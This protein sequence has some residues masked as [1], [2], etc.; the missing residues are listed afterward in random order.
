MES[1]IISK[2]IIVPETKSIRAEF[3]EKG[4]CRSIV[5]EGNY[6]FT[7]D[8]KPVDIINASLKYYGFDL[9]GAISGSKSVIGSCQAPPIRI[10]GR[11]N[12]YW[13]P[14]TLPHHDECVWF[15]LHHVEAILPEGEDLSRIYLKGGPCF[16]LNTTAKA[17]SEKY[18]RTEKYETKISKRTENTLSFIMERTTDIY[19]VEKGKRN[20]V[21]TRKKD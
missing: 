4:N 1:T 17:L 19:S 10:P 5:L 14:H 3:D 2:Y 13:F 6:T 9:N 16:K 20:Y 15:A 12:M 18:D 21:I 7:V 11:M 8:M